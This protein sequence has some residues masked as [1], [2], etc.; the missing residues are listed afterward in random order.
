MAQFELLL[1]IDGVILSLRRIWRAAPVN[2]SQQPVL[3]ARE[4]VQG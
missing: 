2:V 1:L 4:T 3:G